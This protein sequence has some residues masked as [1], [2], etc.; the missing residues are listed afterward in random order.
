[1]EIKRAGAEDLEGL[2]GG[3]KLSEQEQRVVKGAW[4]SGARED[5]RHP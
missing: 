4:Q 1:M 5:G 2:M 3:L